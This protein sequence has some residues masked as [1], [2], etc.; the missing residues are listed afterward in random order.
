MI[1]VV[2]ALIL[3]VVVFIITGFTV[4]RKEVTDKFGNP[5]V[6]TTRK[7]KANKKNILA[8]LQLFLPVIP[9]FS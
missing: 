8:V 7:W 9:A 4:T 2:A 6:V 3:A 1:W 5:R